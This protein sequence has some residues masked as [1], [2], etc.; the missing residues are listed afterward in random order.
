MISGHNFHYESL[1]T[2]VFQR[3]LQLQD[4]LKL[5]MSAFSTK[6]PVVLENQTGEYQGSG[7]PPRRPNSCNDWA[8]SNTQQALRYW[9]LNSSYA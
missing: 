1:E 8:P 6:V 4:G 2:E 7:V 5:G 3:I 9:S